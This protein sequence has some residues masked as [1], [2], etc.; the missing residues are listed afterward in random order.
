MGKVRYIFLIM[1]ACMTMTAMAGS[2]KT[3]TFVKTDG[4]TVSFST[5]GLVI[6]YDDFAH[7]VVTN[8]ETSAIINLVEVD[9]MCFDDTGS[10]SIIDDVNGDGEVNVA[11]VNAV[12]DIILGGTADDN[13]STRADVNGD[14]EVNIADVNTLIDL[15]LAS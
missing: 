10:T 6:T 5:S 9:Y 11:D 4:Q 8:D 3:L 14:D 2:D 7:A 13:T 12:I 1:A 15:I